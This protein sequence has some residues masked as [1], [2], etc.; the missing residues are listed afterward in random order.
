METR[1]P[2]TSALEARK[3]QDNSHLSGP[4]GRCNYPGTWNSWKYFANNTNNR[5]PSGGDI[6]K[7]FPTVPRAST[8]AIQRLEKEKEIK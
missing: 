4:P 7:I 5:A 8:G 3:F 1:A 6:S 2:E